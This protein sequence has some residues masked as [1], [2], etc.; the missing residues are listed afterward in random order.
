MILDINGKVMVG[1][2]TE[3]APCIGVGVIGDTA[4]PLV[5]GKA[6]PQVG[7][8][9]PLGPDPEG[10]LVLYLDSTFGWSTWSES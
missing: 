9:N 6:F 4:F 3:F 7:T 5:R 10:E 8:E 1:D 2:G